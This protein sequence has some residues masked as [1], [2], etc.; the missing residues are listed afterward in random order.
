MSLL[1]KKINFEDLI[2]LLLI[3]GHKFFEN[4]F[5]QIITTTDN[6][7]MLTDDGKRRLFGLT[8]PL[9]AVNLIVGKDIHFLNKISHDDFS[10]KLG[11]TYVKYLQDVKQADKQEI[12]IRVGEVA[13][14]IKIWTEIKAERLEETDWE[15]KKRSLF[16]INNVDDM[17]KFTLCCAF[18]EVYSVGNV[19]DSIEEEKN[20]VAFKL[21]KYFVKNDMMGEFLKEFNVTLTH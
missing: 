16:E 2:R 6:R 15:P 18:A 14:I 8:S 17:E 3:Y 13:R 4:E 1:K 21:A 7:K 9:V 19:S 10:D 20:I 12:D 11:R 5:D